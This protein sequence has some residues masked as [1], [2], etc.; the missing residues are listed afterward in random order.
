MIEKGT[1]IR[2]L[3]H[4][5]LRLIDWMGDDS[6]I[7]EA[8][9]IS[10]KSPSKGEEQDKKLLAYLYKNKHTSPFEQCV[11]TFN[12]K[13]PLFVQGQ[14]VRHRTQRLNQVSA[15]YTELPEEFY[16]PDKWRR[17]DN[18]N[19]QGSSGEFDNE[20]NWAITCDFERYCNKSYGYYQS[21][22]NSGVSREMARMVL[23]QNIY[24]EIYSQWDLHNLMHFLNLRLDNHA[25]YEIREYAK[26]MCSIFEQLYPWTH[27]AFTK[28][29]FEL[30]EKQ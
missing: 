29:K 18:K 22:L 30:T 25:Q 10:Y 11:I 26:A 23:P 9:R 1:T 16:I 17:Q 15:R 12:I 21:L 28:Y 5:F 24:T 2:V 20:M 4:G 7:V 6:R 27:E 13:L 14:M 8:A 19:K 3:D